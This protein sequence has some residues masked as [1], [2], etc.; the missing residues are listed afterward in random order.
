[1]PDDKEAASAEAAAAFSNGRPSTNEFRW[2]AKDARVLWVR[3]ASSVIS[4][5]AGQAVGMRGVTIDITE[6]KRAETSV[7]LL[8]QAGLVLNES[9]D[10]E[11]TMT[12]LSNVLVPELADWCSVHVIEDDEVKQVALAHRDPA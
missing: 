1:H 10:Y 7:D 6:Q 4:D 8:S 11:V 9:L 5:E 2:V 12:N 3:A